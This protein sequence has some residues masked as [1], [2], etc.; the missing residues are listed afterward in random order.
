MSG[1]CIYLKVED[2]LKHFLT[3]AFGNPVK[4]KRDSP[5]ARIMRE[6]IMQTPE[7]ASPDLGQDSNLAVTIPYF[8]EADPRTYNYMGKKAKKALIDSFDHLLKAT[9]FSELGALENSRRGELSKQVYAWM[10]K[11][12]IPEENWYTVSQKY[13]RMRRKYMK[14]GIKL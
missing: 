5:E 6:F 12:G 8:K 9:M 4:V 1:F 11:H 7:G 10:E 3:T 2:Y 14:N 13:Y